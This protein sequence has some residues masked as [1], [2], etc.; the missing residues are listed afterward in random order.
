[1][2]QDTHKTPV[3]FRLFKGELI[4]IFPDELGTR[5]PKTCGMYA[6]VGQYSYC[7]AAILT[8]GKPADPESDKVKGLI[9]ELHGLGYNLQIIPGTLD[10]SQRRT[11]KRQRYITGYIKLPKHLKNG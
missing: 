8:H 6:H 3:N 7:D 10:K 9:S 1:M 5:D 2:H 11:A 4:A